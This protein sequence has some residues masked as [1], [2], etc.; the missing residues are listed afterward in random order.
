MCSWVL[1]HLL[2][3]R[4]LAPVLL[5]TGTQFC[6]LCLHVHV[7]TTVWCEAR[8]EET[9][10][11]RCARCMIALQVVFRLWTDGWP[12]GAAVLGD[13]FA[14]FLCLLCPAM[15]AMVE[16]LMDEVV[17]ECGYCLSTKPAT[18]KIESH[19][20]GM[21]A[22][23]YGLRQIGIKVE[24]AVASEKDASAAKYHLLNHKKFKHLF[25]DMRYLAEGCEGPCY[26]HGGR[27]CSLKDKHTGQICTPDLLASSFVCKPWSRASGKRFKR[28]E[29]APA[30]GDDPDVDTFYFTVECI[31][32]RAPHTFVLENVDA[33]NAKAS[34]SRDQ[35]SPLQW[36]VRQLQEIRTASSFAYEV[37]AVPGITGYMFG[38][39]QSRSRTLFFGVRSDQAVRIK[40]VVAS[41]FAFQR[42]CLKAHSRVNG[43]A[44]HI[45]T[46]IEAVRPAAATS[47]GE[48]DGELDNAYIDYLSEYKKGIDLLRPTV[49][50]IASTKADTAHHS[51][52][53]SARVRATI[54]L[55]TH[56][57]IKNVKPGNYPIADVSQRVDRCKVK[58]DGTIPTVLCGSVLWDFTQKNF[59][60]P[61]VIAASMGYSAGSFYDLPLGERR[62]MV[63]NG[64]IVPIAA[65]AVA[66]ACVGAGFLT[67]TTI[68]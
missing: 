3:M 11:V 35:E 17:R 39:C 67:K 63:G 46:Y 44:D 2:S 19:C 22:V 34:N 61:E 16:P 58:Y 18:M 32:R 10:C 55:L 23:A 33:L 54:D 20:A 28:S 30:L 36:M 6:S 24:S 1:Q 38:V 62:K 7:Q 48:E 51:K 68:S 53:T 42:E 47:A 5:Q 4:A 27:L 29:V 50:W 59:V 37:E 25:T 65:C 49:S 45:K 15:A 14:D 26:K 66:A 9:C 57:V 21:D 52:I 64:F 13:N 8:C 40:T 56:I 60:S 12:V 31:K 43:G 41:F